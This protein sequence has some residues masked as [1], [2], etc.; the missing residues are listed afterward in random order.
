[1][2]HRCLRDGVTI[3]TIVGGV[4]LVW[5]AI[6]AGAIEV[7]QNHAGRVVVRGVLSEPGA[8]ERRPGTHHGADDRVTGTVAADMDPERVAAIGLL[9][10]T[11]RQD[12]AGA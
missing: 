12:D 11:W 2:A 3:G 9:V 7:Q 4:D 6:R 10:E 5:V 1:M 8:P